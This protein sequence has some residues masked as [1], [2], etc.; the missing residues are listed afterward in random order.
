MNIKEK[1]FFYILIICT[2]LICVSIIAGAF[3]IRSGII[4]NANII[5]DSLSYNLHS[6]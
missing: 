6:H 5:N 4:E 3:I 1:K 2:L